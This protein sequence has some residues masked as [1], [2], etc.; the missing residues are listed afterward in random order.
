MGNLKNR[1]DLVLGPNGL[2]DCK[3]SDETEVQIR[4]RIRH[5]VSVAIFVC[6]LFCDQKINQVISSKRLAGKVYIFTCSFRLDR[7]VQIK[8]G[9]RP[10]IWSDLEDLTGF[11]TDL[12]DQTERLS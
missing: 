2:S 9:L 10:D 5:G 1:S 12:E 6:L 11:W 3:L 7:I 4:T 8:F